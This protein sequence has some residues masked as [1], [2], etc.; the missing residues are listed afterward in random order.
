MSKIIEKLKTFVKPETFVKL[1]ILT[2][3]AL[4]AE[5]TLHVLLSWPI[6][7]KLLG[8]L[9]ALSWLGNKILKF[10]AIGVESESL[11]EAGSKFAE[12][13]GTIDEN[14]IVMPAIQRK[15]LDIT[16]NYISDNQL[17][18]KAVVEL[19]DILL[20]PIKPVDSIA[21]TV[22]TLAASAVTSLMGEEA[23]TGN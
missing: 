5:D 23:T 15:A 4:Q 14:G 11:S 6:T 17:V 9:F 1:E 13:F 22:Y 7:Q 10:T 20:A 12:S 19:T 16:K 21:H 2:V 3:R 18:G 8:K